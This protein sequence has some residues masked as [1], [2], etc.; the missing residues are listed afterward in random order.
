[1]FEKVARLSEDFQK[2]ENEKSKKVTK[3]IFL[4]LENNEI[5]GLYYGT[6]YDHK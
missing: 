1:M 4:K 5:C 3:L 6:Y 2:I